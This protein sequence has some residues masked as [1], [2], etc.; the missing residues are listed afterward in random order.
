[1]NDQTAWQHASIT[2]LIKGEASRKHRTH[3]TSTKK[4]ISARLINIF[5]GITRLEGDELHTP[6]ISIKNL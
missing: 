6:T 2:T 3:V 4:G 5:D 1:M